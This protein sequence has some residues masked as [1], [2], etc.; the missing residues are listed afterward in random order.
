VKTLLYRS[1]GIVS[2]PGGQP[3]FAASV[4]PKGEYGPL[5]ETLGL[6][7][8]SLKPGGSTRL[9]PLD[10]GLVIARSNSSRRDA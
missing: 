3:R 2:S 7:R 6:A 8:L 9:N 5:A 1:I 4:D 10:P